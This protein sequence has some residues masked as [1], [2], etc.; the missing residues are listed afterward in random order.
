MAVEEVRAPGRPR[1]PA[2]DEMIARAALEE[3]GAVGF[4]NASIAGIARR[5]GVA[6]TTLYRRWQ[7]KLELILDLVGQLRRA[8][9]VPVSGDVRRDLT[10]QLRNVFRRWSE[11]GLAQALV[12]IDAEAAR[13]TTLG[14]AWARNIL[15]PWRAHLREMLD[16][17]VASGQVR[18]DA[19]LDLVLDVLTAMVP[20]AVRRWHDDDLDSLPTRMVGTLLDGIGPAQPAGGP[21]TG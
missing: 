17:G 4:A 12:E 10:G 6:R 2:V 14:A 1:D 16:A 11:D 9:E 21:P 19:D 3:L 5:A 7:S 20:F 18:P 15:D 13:G 8:D